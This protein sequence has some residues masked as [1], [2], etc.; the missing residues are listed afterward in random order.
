MN[1]ETDSTSLAA[2]GIATQQLKLAKVYVNTRSRVTMGFEE[3]AAVGAEVVRKYHAEG[4][5]SAIKFERVR[6]ELLMQFHGLKAK[7]QQ[8]KLIGDNK[9]KLTEQ[10]DFEV[11]AEWLKS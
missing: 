7:G 8:G 2:Y 3:T 5:V 10:S 6:R 4:Q 11:P 1:F 9:D